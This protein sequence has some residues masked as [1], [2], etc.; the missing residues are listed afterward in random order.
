[1]IKIVRG[2]EYDAVRQA[3]DEA[4]SEAG[5]RSRVKSRISWRR[6]RIATPAM[7]GT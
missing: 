7:C 5:R 1:M 6:S 3:Y 2:P 4:E